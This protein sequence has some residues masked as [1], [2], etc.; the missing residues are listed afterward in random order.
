MAK[1]WRGGRAILTLSFRIN[2]T[3]LERDAAA[4]GASSAAVPAGTSE[5]D[6]CESQLKLDGRTDPL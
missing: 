4:M 2:F 1:L 5:V 3:V 6:S